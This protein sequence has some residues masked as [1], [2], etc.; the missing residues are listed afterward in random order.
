MKWLGAGLAGISLA[1]TAKANP[2]SAK[3]PKAF[4]TYNF[5]TGPALSLQDEDGDEVKGKLVDCI[6][7]PRENQEERLFVLRDGTIVANLEGYRISPTDEALEVKLYHNG[8]E[9]L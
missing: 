3:T 6:I 2:K 9:V 7:C 4:D 8:E 5:F 1:S